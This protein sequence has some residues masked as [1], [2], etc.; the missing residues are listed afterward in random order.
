MKS[1]ILFVTLSLAQS[2]LALEW[3]SYDLSTQAVSGRCT[4]E[5]NSFFFF[6][7]E[8]NNKNPNQ[9]KVK[10][11]QVIADK[12]NKALTDLLGTPGSW[13]GVFNNP[14][15]EKECNPNNSDVPLYSRV[16]VTT[17]F[18]N[19][20]TSLA[21]TSDSYMGGAHG[22]GGI[23]YLVLAASGDV[24]RF[25]NVLDVDRKTF[26]YSVIAKLVAQNKYY[27]D[28]FASW[29]KE[30]TQGSIELNYMADEHGFTV[31]FNQYAV[32]SYA[33]GPIE[34]TFNWSELKDLIK[35][36]SVFKDYLK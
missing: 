16:N 6:P 31:M 10:A 14:N 27:A 29:E 28:W 5:V 25:S 20:W 7:A 33:D 8:L 30:F 12:M 35:K 36:D 23:S 34:I 13:A 22:I 15:F 26:T 1:L 9:S 24:V 3:S 2:A 21:I 18:T 17:K 32:A 19:P 4:S 11:Q